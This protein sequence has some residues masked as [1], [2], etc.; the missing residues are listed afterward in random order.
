M[1]MPGKLRWYAWWYFAIGAG[2][3]LLAIQRFLQG[4]R[5]WLVPLRVIIAGGFVLLGYWQ[6]RASK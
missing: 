2:F 3:V 5:S 1:R 6:H 4:E